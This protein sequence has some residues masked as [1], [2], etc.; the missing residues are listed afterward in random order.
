MQF[1]FSGDFSPATEVQHAENSIRSGKIISQMN[2]GD[3]LKKVSLE[4]SLSY[5]YWELAISTFN[6][7]VIYFQIFTPS[8]GINV[9]DLLKRAVK[10]TNLRLPRKNDETGVDSK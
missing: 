9:P 2:A 7:P 6:V 3:F 10:M 4:V 5:W 1:G 8:H